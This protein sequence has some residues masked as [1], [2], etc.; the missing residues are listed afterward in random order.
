V[1]LIIEQM[2][3]HLLPLIEKERAEAGS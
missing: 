1:A 2:L 3:P